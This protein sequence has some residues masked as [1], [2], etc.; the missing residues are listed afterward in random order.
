M[1]RLLKE[2]FKNRERLV[3]KYLVG[4]GAAG[5]D[6]YKVGRDGKDKYMV[7]GGGSAVSQGNNSKFVNFGSGDPVVESKSQ[8]DYP[9][10]NESAVN[11][12]G[13]RGD[14][15]NFGGS[16][17]NGINQQ[18][19]NAGGEIKLEYPQDEEWSVKKDAMARRK[20]LMES[21]RDVS[22]GSSQYNSPVVDGYP[23]KTAK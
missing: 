16:V 20:G 15:S 19:I 8:F 9:Y 4:K 3:D 13:D 18:K 1:R 17:S 11:D 14:N 10:N 7:G 22:G 5:K 21:M 12:V 23:D 6:Q 2:K